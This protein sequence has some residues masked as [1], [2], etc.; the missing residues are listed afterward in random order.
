VSEASETAGVQESTTLRDV[1]EAVGA[2]RHPHPLR[3]PRKVLPFVKSGSDT[4]LISQRSPDQPRPT[5]ERSAG[6]IDPHP[7]RHQPYSG[8]DRRRKPSSAQQPHP[9][10]RRTDHL[11]RD[12]KF[13]PEMSSL[14]SSTTT[15]TTRATSRTAPGSSRHS[16]LD[17]SYSSSAGSFETDSGPD[18]VAPALTRTRAKPLLGSDS[19]EAT[20]N[21]ISTAEKR[22]NETSAEGSAPAITPKTRRTVFSTEFAAN[23]QDTETSTNELGDDTSTANAASPRTTSAKAILQQARKRRWVLPAAGIALLGLFGLGLTKCGSAST[24]RAETPKTSN[25]IETVG[26]GTSGKGTPAVIQRTVVGGRDAIGNGSILADSITQTPR[27][28][29]VFA[30]G[31]KLISDTTSARIIGRDGRIRAVADP[32]GLL[33]KPGAAI[34]FGDDIVIIDQASASL[35][36]IRA[37]GSISRLSSDTQF[38]APTGIASLDNQT[39][40]V[41]D[42]GAGALFLVTTKAPST[43]GTSTKDA[44]TNDT[45]TNGAELATVSPLTVAPALIRPIAVAHRGNQ[46]LA[47]VDDADGAIYE[48]IGGSGRKIAQARSLQAGVSEPVTAT[49]NAQEPATASTE[50]A[51]PSTEPATPSD[52]QSSNSSVAADSTPTD[53]PAPPSTPPPLSTV[54]ALIT[55]PETVVALAARP[56]GSLWV[57]GRS[58][59]LTLIPSNNRGTAT[60]VSQN[61]NWPQ[62]LGVDARGR[63]LIADTGAHKVSTIDEKGVLNYV[64]GG[65]HSPAY[66]ANTTVADDLVLQSASSFATTDTGDLLVA[67]E[68]ANTVWGITAG[69][70]SYRLVGNGTRTAGSEGGQGPDTPIVAPTSLA[71]APD[72]STYFAEPSTGRI[73]RVDAKGVVTTVFDQ[74]GGPI[75]ASEEPVVETTVAASSTDPNVDP[76]ALAPAPTTTAAPPSPAV[77]QERRRQASLSVGRLGLIAVTKDGTVLAADTWTHKLGVVRQGAFVVKAILSSQPIGIAVSAPETS[78]GKA[79]IA[80]SERQRVEVFTGTLGST[81]PLERSVGE[82][83]LSTAPQSGTSFGGIASAETGSFAVISSVALAPS[84]KVPLQL[85]R[86]GIQAPARPGPVSRMSLTG[87]VPLGALGTLPTGEFVQLSSNGGLFAQFPAST[88]AASPTADTRDSTGDSATDSTPDS[89]ANSTTDSSIVSTSVSAMV[90]A[91]E[92][93]GSPAVSSAPSGLRWLTNPAQTTQESGVGRTPIHDPGAITS[94]ADGT[95]VFA[96]NGAGKVRMLRNGHLTVLAGSGRRSPAETRTDA[97][98]ATFDRLSALAAHANG[99]IDFSTADGL[100]GIDTVGLVRRNDDP[101]VANVAMTVTTNDET[102]I[103]NNRTGL[104]QRITKSGSFE[105]LPGTRIVNASQLTAAGDRFYVLSGPETARTV[106]VRRGTSETSVPLPSNANPIAMTADTQGTL[107]VLDSQHRLLRLNQPTEPGAAAPENLDRW[108]IVDMTKLRFGDERFVGS[109]DTA[110]PQAMA[111]AGPGAVAISDAG[112][113]TIRVIRFP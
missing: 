65:S 62:G 81:K 57:L 58:S 78:A 77:R 64:V 37:D 6:L 50:A 30:D 47:V 34:A 33:Q 108:N 86:P 51:T 38:R 10:R 44:G 55:L 3:R 31:R 53:A 13:M 7:P 61:L 9:S 84:S 22:A 11:Y 1:G 12:P 110:E 100:T 16:L 23:P 71:T 73:R 72:G 113:D 41:A 70:A 49:T 63:A 39:L 85:V 40:V 75:A 35:V 94:S 5:D 32:T 102:V 90:S 68:S 18:S 20:A 107:Y 56:D 21:Q 91:S 97:T 103:V 101:A 93:P 48:V 74:F 15:A 36:R 109:P 92:E 42:P 19:P 43:N 66:E 60:V 104:L 27:G 98:T 88:N 45:T 106:T 112:S 79:T 76:A 82:P 17:A 89:A 24:N 28:A 96:E 8:P 67:D 105:D 29:A 4:L 69:G 52:P 83:A 59:T 26:S 54:D 14:G 99:S 87:P 25:A 111:V 95:L 80:V 46:T 2:G